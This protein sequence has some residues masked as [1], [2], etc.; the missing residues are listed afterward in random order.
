MTQ[1][2]S[3]AAEILQFGP[4]QQDEILIRATPPP[5]SEESVTRATPLPT[6][7]SLSVPQEENKE[8]N[9]EENLFILPASTAPALLQTN[10]RPKRA[11]GPTLDGYARGQ[12][13]SAETR[14]I[15]TDTRHNTIECIKSPK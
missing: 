3:T 10:A 14:Q 2:A 12:A 13:E 8:E 7:D 6:E 1:S 5:P 9:K 15:G 11:R 4:G